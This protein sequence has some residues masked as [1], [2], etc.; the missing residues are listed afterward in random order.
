MAKV[1]FSQPG[2][3]NL[4]VEV[5]TVVTPVAGVTVETTTTAAAP[6]QP[7]QSQLPATIP[8]GGVARPL[9][10]DDA[11]D[12]IDARDMVIP[13]L[14]I[15]QKV[16]E[17]SN[18]FQGGTI[19]L[20]SQSSGQLVLADGPKP[21]QLSNAIRLIVLGT[22]PKRYVE[23]VEGGARGDMFDTEQQVVAA[24]GTTDYNEAKSSGKRLFQT[25]ITA[26]CLIE[27]TQG[28]DDMGFP[29]TIEGKRYALALYSMKGTSYTNAAKHF[30]SSKKIGW[31]A[32]KGFRGGVWTLR[33][34]LEHRNGNYYYIPVVKPAEFTTEAFR[35][36]VQNHLGF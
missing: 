28:S 3:E 30:L 6:A 16:G 2:G 13:Y 9:Y 7:A 29:I 24:N 22:R 31:L 5:E 15:V 11:E 19:L 10:V 34:K 32:G 14:S 1:S 36:A 35:T 12:N 25:L 27:Q 4:A 33:S 26:L 8:S 18:L 21:N 23:K 20:G 17:T